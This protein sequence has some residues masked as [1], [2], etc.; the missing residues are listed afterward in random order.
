M[1]SSQTLVRL[2]L[3]GA[4]LATAAASDLAA[5]TTRP[6]RP[7][8]ATQPAA[9]AQRAGRKQVGVAQQGHKVRAQGQRIQK[10]RLLKQRLQRR[11]M[12]K[13]RMANATPEQR[14]VM[15]ARMQARNI[16]A[17]T[18]REQVKAGTLDRAAARARMQEWRKQNMPP[19]AAKVRP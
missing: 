1:R 18:I 15:K 11:K 7:S 13:R 10:Q 9:P 16:E 5:Q 6:V 8:V 19:Q 4:V 14:E 2:F 12:M 3:A 17:Q